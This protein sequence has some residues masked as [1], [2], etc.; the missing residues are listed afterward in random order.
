[1]PVLQ[2]KL[3]PGKMKGIQGN[4]NLCY[5][6]SAIFALFSKSEVLDYMISPV[7]NENETNEVTKEL[8]DIMAW[9]IIYPLRE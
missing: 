1:M 9:K 2:S 5:F 6:E 7:L 4:S 3:S 8:R